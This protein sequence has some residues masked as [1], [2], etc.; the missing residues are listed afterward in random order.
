MG[1]GVREVSHSLVAVWAMGL[2][3]RTSSCVGLRHVKGGAQSS[4]FTNMLQQ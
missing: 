4:L 1:N 2:K 3:V